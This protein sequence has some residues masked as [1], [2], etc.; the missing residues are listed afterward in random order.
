MP[1]LWLT[2]AAAAGAAISL[3]AAANGSLRT[4]LGDARYAAFFSICG[5]MIMAAVAMLVIRPPFPAATALRAAPWWNWI[6]GPLGASIV[7]AGAVLTPAGSGGI[8]FGGGG[9]ATGLLARARPFRGDGRAAAAPHGR[10][11]GRS[12]DD[13]RRHAPGEIP[14]A[15][16]AAAQSTRFALST[17]TLSPY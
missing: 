15:T 17:V 9:G 1:A 5:T 11:R 10:P 7:L 13:R 3:Q 12:G 8:H 6:G 4:N 2:L 16:V 14:V